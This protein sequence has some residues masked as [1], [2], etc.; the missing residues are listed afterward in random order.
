[1]KMKILFL[2]C[3]FFAASTAFSQDALGYLK[4]SDEITHN[5]KF[6]GLKDLVVDLVSP[7][8]SKQ[9]NDQKIFGNVQEVSFRIYWTAQPERIAIEVFG[10]PDGFREIKEELKAVMVGRLESIIPLALERKLQGYQFKLDPKKP[11]TVSAV[12][13]SY[14]RPIPEYE[15]TFDT[16]GKLAT[17]VAKKPVGQASTTL[18]WAKA[19]WSE[20]RFY[21]TRMSARS[22]EGPQMTETET[23]TVWQVIAGIGVPTSV[24]TRIK[25]TLKQPGAGSK[26]IERSIEE[27][28]N[29]KNYKVN[30]GEAMKWFLGHSTAAP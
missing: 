26:P 6:R 16:D 27:T 4:K 3:A 28:L 21:V 12:D 7:Q 11:R 25:Q 29:F 23:D 24:R 30:V 10:L 2:L 5:P 8:M 20:P 14:Q 13:P 19:P 1:M 9:L 18:T 15:L 17:M 22:E